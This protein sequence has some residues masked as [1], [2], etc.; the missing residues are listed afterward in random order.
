MLRCKINKN[1][2]SGDIIYLI[3]LVFFMLLGFFLMIPGRKKINKRNR[4][5]I[6]LNLLLMKRRGTLN[7]SR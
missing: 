1:M 7:V 6:I 4:P 2:E 5:V 3:L